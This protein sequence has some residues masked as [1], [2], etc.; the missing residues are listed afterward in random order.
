MVIPGHAHAELQNKSSFQA[1]VQRSS[2]L[3]SC[4]NMSFLQYI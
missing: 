3:P 4:Y 1:E 2:A